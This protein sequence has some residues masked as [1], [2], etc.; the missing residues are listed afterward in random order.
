MGALFG[1][2]DI[3]KGCHE[4]CG[5]AG[6]HRP[7]VCCISGIIG[8]GSKR[9]DDQADD[10]WQHQ[11]ADQQSL[12]L[13]QIVAQNRVF[14]RAAETNNAPDVA[15]LMRAFEPILLRLAE[16]DIAPEDAEALRRQLSFE[17][18]A[19]LTKMQRSTSEG[20]ESI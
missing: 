7:G 18:K 20:A 6:K 16:Q 3:Q 14:E 19:M 12:L 10:E 2:D 17:M 13:M 9:H 4:A 1:N 15:R 5:N 8:D 11:P